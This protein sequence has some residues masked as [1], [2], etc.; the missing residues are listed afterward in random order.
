MIKLTID[1]KN[2]D[3][4][5]EWSELTLD[6]WQKISEIDVSSEEEEFRSYYLVIYVLSIFN[7]MG[8]LTSLSIPDI[9]KIGNNMKY[10]YE[11]PISTLKNIIKIDNKE[12]GLEESMFSMSSGSYFDTDRLVKKMKNID[13]LHILMASF[14]RPIKKK[15]K[16]GF[17]IEDYDTTS[18]NERAEIFKKVS[19]LEA[20]AFIN[21]IIAHGVACIEHFQLFTT[22]KLAEMKA[23]QVSKK[24]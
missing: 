21:F 20:A 3:V 1:D 11:S 24:A 17:E 6:Q 15:S 2:Y 19:A 9:I 8:D 22:Q 10:L 23:D 18:L 4:P 12:Y 14:Y 13:K 5:S 16:K 7:I